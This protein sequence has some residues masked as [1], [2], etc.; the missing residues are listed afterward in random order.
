M[1]S[2][3]RTQGSAAEPRDSWLVGHG[4]SGQ[5]NTGNG[6]G[7]ALVTGKRLLGTKA[8]GQGAHCCQS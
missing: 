3:L 5:L 6:S 2:D 4:V 7:N 1:C 8:T